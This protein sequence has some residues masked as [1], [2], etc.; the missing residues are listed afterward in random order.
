MRVLLTAFRPFGGEVINPSE[1]A[2]ELIRL[3]GEVTLDKAVISTEYRRSESEL[4][5]LIAESDPDVAICLGQAG[6]RRCITPER[7]AVNID[8][9]VM[10]DN[11]GEIRRGSRICE[12]GPSAYFA[13]LPVEK[14]C[15][16]LNDAGIESAVSNSAGTFVCN[17][18]MYTA[19][20]VTA[21][22]PGKK[23]GFIHVPYIPEQ[24]AG[25]PDG[26][27]AMELAKIVRGIEIAVN[28]SC[29]S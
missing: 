12:G 6:G 29:S 14:I 20:H 21:G 11:S 19:L 1:K 7:I 26:T 5:E 18:L 15:G 25:K 10:P 27:P 16:A 24:L 22:R 3:T 4:K 28:V 9:S 8:D 13:T 23:A 2:L 17:H